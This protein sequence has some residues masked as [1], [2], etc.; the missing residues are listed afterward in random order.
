M[1]HQIGIAQNI[2]GKIIDA[3]TQESIPYANIRVNDS[4][5][6]VSNAEGFFTLSESNSSEQTKLSISYLGYANQQINVADLKKSNFI[7]QC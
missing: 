7:I 2:K 3:T 4:E 1:L 5:N 6:L